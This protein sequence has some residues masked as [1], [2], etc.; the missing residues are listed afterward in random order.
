MFLNGEGRA[1]EILHSWNHY[2]FSFAASSSIIYRFNVASENQ[3]INVKNIFNISEDLLKE[4][5]ISLASTKEETTEPTETLENGSETEHTPHQNPETTLELAPTE[6][7][8]PIPVVEA[9]EVKEAPE[10]SADP[11]VRE[12]SPTKEVPVNLVPKKEE[13]EVKLEEKVEP[14]IEMIAA[15]IKVKNEEQ[16]APKPPQPVQAVNG[17]VGKVLL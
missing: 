2:Y 13:T 16:P 11:E 3:F 17:D 6:K 9:K 4:D 7:D 15:P 14:D 1:N 12:P 8:N 5:T 10:D